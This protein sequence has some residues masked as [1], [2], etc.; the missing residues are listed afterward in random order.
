[1]W[2][3]EFQS[4]AK[5][6]GSGLRPTVAFATASS[7]LRPVKTKEDGVHLHP[8]T[9]GLAAALANL[10]DD[11]FVAATVDDAEAVCCWHVTAR[12]VRRLAT[13]SLQSHARRHDSLAT[14]GPGASPAL[15]PRALRIVHGVSCMCFA[16]VPAAAAGGGGG[17][18]SSN[19]K[20]GV[21]LYLVVA[22]RR[23]LLVLQLHDQRAPGGACLQQASGGTAQRQW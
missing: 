5:S 14:P 8:A 13:L 10:G 4:L 20:G 17:Y 18:S 7:Q 1:V 11:D 23:S 22:A 15:S 9:A 16:R 12:G 3:D 19:S 2:N 21:D 6:D